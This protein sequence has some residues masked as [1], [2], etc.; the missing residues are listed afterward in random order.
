MNEFLNT[1]GEF[2]DEIITWA[3]DHKDIEG[4]G[5][6]GSYARG[7]Q[8][9]DSDIDVMVF[10]LSPERFLSDHAWLKLFGKTQ[11]VAVEDWGGVQ[12]VRADFESGMEIE[13]NFGRLAWA[14]VP[15]DSGT[16]EV[17]SNGFDVLYDPS[18][19][20]SNL[21]NHVLGG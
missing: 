3:K 16:A 6:V 12:T 20:L 18:G 10:C 19:R 5:I 15:V 2:K 17:V 14:N 11:K 7:E 4:L 9:E 13:F 8:R 21:R 1:Y